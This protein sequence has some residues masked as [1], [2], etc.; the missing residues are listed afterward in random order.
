M[1]QYQ[2]SSFYFRWYGKQPD[3]LHYGL[4][5]EADND[6]ERGA[7]IFLVIQR[8]ADPNMRIV[9]ARL[10]CRFE[11]LKQKIRRNNV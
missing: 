6:N 5:V 9:V 2:P 1:R 3:T 7:N 10:L 4:S 11:C 8:V